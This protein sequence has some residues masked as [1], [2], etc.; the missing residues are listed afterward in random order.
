MLRMSI[1][2]DTHYQSEHVTDEYRC[3][4]PLPKSQVYYICMYVVW[5]VKGYS[6][7]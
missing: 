5:T 6:Q 3:R 4:Y 1:G 2:A 7:L